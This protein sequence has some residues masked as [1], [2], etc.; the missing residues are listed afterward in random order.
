[1]K[2]VTLGGFDTHPAPSPIMAEFGVQ[3]LAFFVLFH[4]KF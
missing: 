2:F 1:M 4:A 3:N